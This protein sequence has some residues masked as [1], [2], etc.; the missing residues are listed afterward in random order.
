M[1]KETKKEREFEVNKVW[2]KECGRYEIHLSKVEFL[3]Y[4]KIN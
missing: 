4:E 1:K 3:K 2:C